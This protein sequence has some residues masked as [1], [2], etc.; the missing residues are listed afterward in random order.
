MTIS[1]CLQSFIDKCVIKNLSSETIKFYQ[2]QFHVFLESLDNK[3]CLKTDI[4]SH[5]IDNFILYLRK[6]VHAMILHPKSQ[7]KIKRTYTDGEL[8]VLLKK[9]N[10]KTCSFTE[11]KVWV[12]T[13]YLLA[14]GNRLSSALG[15]KIGDLDFQN[16]LIHVNQVKNRKAQMIPMSDT[17]CKILK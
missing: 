5:D 9:P 14:T 10:L 16:Q 8:T 11:Y 7:Q 17:L 4:I 2:N 1:K 12:Y 6:R 15:L 3:E 13:N